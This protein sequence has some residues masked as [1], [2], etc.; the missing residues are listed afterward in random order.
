MTV[1]SFANCVDESFLQVIEA[2]PCAIVIVNRAGRIA[3]INAEAEK[4]LGYS[5]EE[6]IKQYVEILIPKSSRERHPDFRKS[7]L[8]HPQARQIGTG[9]DLHAQRKDGSEVPVE[10][11]L[12]PLETSQGTCVLCSIVD[13]SERKRAEAELLESEG[14]FQTVANAAPVLIWMAGADGGRTFFN[15]SWFDFTGRTAEQELISGWTTGLHPEDLD[16]CLDEYKTS[17]GAHHHFQMEYRL[18]RADG[19]FRWLLDSGTPRFGPGGIFSGY[20]G[21]CVDITDIKNAQKLTRSSQKLDS[22]AALAKRV[23]HDFSNMQSSIIGFSDLLLEDSISAGSASD[24]IHT[25]RE[26]AMHGVEIARK[27]MKYTETTAPSL[28]R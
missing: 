6:L 10:I 1:G 11:G 17:V 12:K 28:G 5:R 8:R 13:I 3:L 24:K 14:R 16:R 23:A 27:L 19:D 20:I 18:R 15:N 25:I 26:I 2:M 7:F 4:L 9:R 21:A 22:L